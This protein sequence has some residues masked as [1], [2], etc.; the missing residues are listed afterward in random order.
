[1]AEKL[2]RQVRQRGIQERPYTDLLTDNAQGVQTQVVNL[3]G[4]RPE[5]LHFVGV[6][7]EQDVDWV[8]LLLAQ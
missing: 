2:S 7:F 6:D 1:M 5:E 8:E 3:G 4:E